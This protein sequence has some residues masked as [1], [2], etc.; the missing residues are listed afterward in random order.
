MF[1]LKNKQ[2]NQGVFFTFGVELYRMNTED[3]IRSRFAVEL[4]MGDPGMSFKPSSS[5]LSAQ[6][7]AEEAIRLGDK[8]KIDLGSIILNYSYFMNFYP[9][10][11]AALNLLY[12]NPDSIRKYRSHYTNL[13]LEEL[14]DDNRRVFECLTQ[15]EKA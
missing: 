10:A 11:G 15:S 13:D 7:L 3:A 9:V 4:V 5:Y 2:E 6:S 1:I 12:P 8:L 14:T